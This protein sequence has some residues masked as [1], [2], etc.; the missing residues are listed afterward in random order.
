M[1]KIMFIS[2]CMVSSIIIDQREKNIR[3]YSCA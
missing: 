2:P 3:L 1:G